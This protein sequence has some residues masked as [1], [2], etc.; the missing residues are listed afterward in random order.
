MM[1]TPTRTP[2]RSGGYHWHENVKR[3]R[4][5]MMRE[6]ARRFMQVLMSDD[7]LSKPEREATLDEIDEKYSAFFHKRKMKPPGVSSCSVQEVSYQDR[8]TLT[9]IHCG[10]PK[11]FERYG[12]P[13]HVQA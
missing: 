12:L 11:E 4:R 9:K 6:D 3:Y 5:A 8:F 1:N 7:D 13:M 10:M 2:Y